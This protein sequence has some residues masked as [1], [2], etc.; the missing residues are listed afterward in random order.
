MYHHSQMVAKCRKA[1]G[2]VRKSK[3]GAS[4]KRWQK[5]KWKDKITGNENVIITTSTE[6]L[7]LLIGRQ[8]M[9]ARRQKGVL[10]TL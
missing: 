3:K 5:E 1:H 8:T 9:W 2:Q 6:M 7:I 10:S 4:L